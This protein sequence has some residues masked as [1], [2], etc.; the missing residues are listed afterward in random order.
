MRK[1]KDGVFRQEIRDE[2][3]ENYK[4]RP[5][6]YGSRSEIEHRETT[7]PATHKFNKYHPS[8]KRPLTREEILNDIL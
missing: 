7:P 8:Y 3:E 4:E 2:G 5:A 6:A 1:S